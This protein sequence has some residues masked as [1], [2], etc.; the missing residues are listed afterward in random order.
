MF[1]IGEKLDMAIYGQGQSDKYRRILDESTYDIEKDV[2]VILQDFLAFRNAL[3]S[4]GINRGVRHFIYEKKEYVVSDL[5]SSMFETTILKKAHKENPIKIKIG[6]SPEG[7]RYD[8]RRKEVFVGFNN[9]VLHYLINAGFDA[10]IALKLLND[11]NIAAGKEL[12]SSDIVY[13]DTIF[14]LFFSDMEIKSILVHEI[15]HWLRDTFSKGKIFS[16]IE[17][18]Y[19]NTFKKIDNIE[20]LIK[21]LSPNSEKMEKVKKLSKKLEDLNKVILRAN[22]KI[23]KYLSHHEI[24]VLIHE[25]KLIYDNTDRGEWNTYSFEDIFKQVSSLLEI[26]YETLKKDKALNREWRNLLFKRMNREGIL[27]KNI[28]NNYREGYERILWS[29]PDFFS[30]NFLTTERGSIRL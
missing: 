18:M 10:K 30:R 24:D 3:I 28:R 12:S 14:N 13:F 20:H 11:E 22:D 27:P 21:V 8:L 19:N 2:D 15:S 6:I 16:S 23:E 1:L 25:I 29:N 7:C 17:I 26:D 9:G 4:G 5:D